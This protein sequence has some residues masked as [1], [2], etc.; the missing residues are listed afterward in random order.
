MSP[1]SPAIQQLLS[2]V[3]MIL[4]LLK[5]TGQVFERNVFQLGLSDIYSWFY[6]G[7]DFREEYHSGEVPISSYNIISGSTWYYHSLLMMMVTDFW[8]RWY[9]SGFTVTATT[10]NVNLLVFPSYTL[11]IS[12][13]SLSPVTLKGRAIKKKCQRIWGHILNFQNVDEGAT[14]KL[15]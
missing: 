2:L 11:F 12:C 15:K 13:K 14:F 9:M 6:W 4:E 5:H 8:S 3:F 7:C 10:M 1:Q